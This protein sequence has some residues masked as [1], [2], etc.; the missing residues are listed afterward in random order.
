[1][2]EF[3][4]PSVGVIIL[5][6]LFPIVGFVLYFV[7]RE[8]ESD[9]AKAYLGAALGGFIVGFIIMMAL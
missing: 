7:K 9:A 1:M 5:S 3:N 4:K 8:L 2:A 6:I